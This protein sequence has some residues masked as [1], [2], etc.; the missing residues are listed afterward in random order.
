MCERYENAL[1]IERV[2]CNNFRKS[3]LS[4]LLIEEQNSISEDGR[5]IILDSINKDNY[6]DYIKP[7]VQMIVKAS[8]DLKY[9]IR[10]CS[11]PFQ[12]VVSNPVGKSMIS[13]SYIIVYII[14]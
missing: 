9:P 1:I 10:N 14:I 4:N 12:E 2:S 7:T 13:Y 3:L 11:R 8:K 5:K 6:Y